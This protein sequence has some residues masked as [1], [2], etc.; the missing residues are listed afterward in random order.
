MKNFTKTIWLSAILMFVLASVG[1]GQVSH[2]VISQ[3]YGGGG[4]SG[5]T[6][7]ND[8]IEIFNP[9]GSN[10]S[11]TGWSVQY[12][13]ATG[14]TWQVTNISGTVNA[15]SYYL[16]QEAAGTG[17]TTYLPT[18]DA[19]GTIAMSSTAGKIALVNNQTALSGQIPNGTGPTI[20]DFVGFGTTAYGFEGSGPTPAP[21]NTTC[22]LRLNGG[23]VDNNQNSTD[24]VTGSP[25]PRNS[26]SPTNSCLLTP[27]A[28]TAAVNPTVD[29]PFDVTFTDDPSWRGAITSITVDGTTLTAGYSTT[30]AGKI[31]FTP[32]ASSPANLLQTSGSDKSIV[33]IATGYNNATVSQTILAGTPTK[34]GMKTQPGAPASNGAVLGTQP[35]V[36]IQDQYGNTTTSTA[37]VIASV[38]S[39]TWTI[40]GTTTKA[41]VS[42]T[43]TFTDLTATSAASVIGATISFTSTGLTGVTSGTFNIP[44]PIP[45]GWQITSAN[46]LYAI[47]FDNTVSGV[48]IGQFAGTGFTTSPSS[49]QL[50]SNAW[51]MNGW[52]DGDLSFGGSNTTG[53]Y[54]RGNSTGGVTTGGVYAFEVS[55]SNKALGFQPGGGD[56]APGTVTLKIQNQTG[57]TI[58]SLSVC[59][60]VYVYNN[61]DRGNSFNFSYSSDNSSYTDISSLDIN[62]DETASVSPSW[63]SYQR[64][65]DI[66]GISIANGE[67]YYLRWS[68]NDV[69]GGGSRDEFALD[70]IKIV[71]NPTS[72]YPPLS[73][74]IDYLA[75]IGNYSLSGDLTVNKGLLLYSALLSLGSSSL[76]L[77]STAVIYGTTSASNMIAATG[78]GE[79]R[80]TFTGTGSFIFPVGD[81]TGTA[82]YSPVT[83]NFT[84]G[85][86]SSAYAGV[87][88][89]NSKFGSNSS[90]TDY[91]DRYWTVTQSGITSFSCD[92]SLYYVDAD[93]HGT[94]ANIYCGSYNGSS[95]TLLNA[96][97]TS[98]NT[99][100][101]TVT[102]FSTF[103][104]GEQGVLP[105]ELHS[106]TSS[107]SANS[108]QLSWSTAV[109]QNNSGFDVE[110]KKTESNNWQKIG[111][112]QGH[113]TTNTPQ[114]YSYSDRYL[115]TGKY[116]YRLKQIDYNGNY[117]YYTLGSEV[118]IGVPKKFE[119]SQ[120]FPNPFNPVTKINYEL[121]NDS[122]VS[123]K[124]FDI[125]G[126]EVGTL[127]DEFKTAGYHTVDFD[128]SSLSSGM[129]F[130][131]IKTN[132]FEAIKKM[133]LIK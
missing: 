39:G 43:A 22:I 33:V 23:C 94:E 91:L 54:A 18:P 122:K 10:I 27:P 108:V 125:L 29:A 66:T 48:N 68:G 102:S 88:L 40:G 32:S 1:W 25:N 8:F 41:G 84:S 5:S 110:R 65:L 77:G 46:T 96:V 93:I 119:V 107:T 24:F 70:D 30:S 111:F 109:E 116:N 6:Y 63:E 56:W 45:P 58:T 114:S 81:N 35:A 83:L 131:R 121:P 50:N 133:L 124:V 127:L 44:S 132:E 51:A 92:V 36:Y 115:P 17:G 15:Y 73:G 31:T 49:G 71:A 118:T 14:T 101:G 57:S 53:D 42:G 98:T 21:S 105:A 99:L 74:S 97:N 82:E 59:Y 2:L 100:S 123:I 117:Q 103:T 11:V 76:T 78:T 130:Y 3:V 72:N 47:D 95:W 52:D 126:R 64:I 79:L 67:Y 112:V 113:G 60:K 89:S 19:T 120:N 129:Y 20:V 75:V 12:A 87:N 4:N 38:G 128:G 85:S 26:S 106:F 55:T 90:S 13:S 86:F 37:D 9:T 62:S 61:E 28:L 16:V 69:S 34:L 7:K 104:G 80:K